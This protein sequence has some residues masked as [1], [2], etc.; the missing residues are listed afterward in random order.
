VN[1]KLGLSGS[2]SL[3]YAWEHA[4]MSYGTLED[5][6]LLA[7]D[8]LVCVTASVLFALDIYTGEVVGT[9]YYRRPSFSVPPP[10]AHGR[11]TAFFVDA[12]ELI[13][14]RLSDGKPPERIVDG[15]PQ[16]AWTAP[17]VRN[18]ISV[19]AGNDVVAV[20]YR[21]DGETR[22]EGFDP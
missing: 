12:D 10:P 14:L 16:P 5:A 19:S 8:R 22:A 2:E 9:P 7:G 4:E 15:R 11:G 3:A 6:P 18:A 17:A 13:A 20:V 1:T 21:D